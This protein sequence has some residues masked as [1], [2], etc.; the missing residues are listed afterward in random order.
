M[1]SF[2]SSVYLARF[3]IAVNSTAYL[4]DT[5]AI[6]KKMKGNSWIQFPMQINHLFLVPSGTLSKNFVK[7]T[8]YI[9]RVI[10]PTDK[11]STKTVIT[12][13]HVTDYVTPLVNPLKGRDVT[14]LY[15]AMQ[16]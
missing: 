6:L 8:F 16:V 10:L 3:L 5:F 4:Q 14:W 1:T 9:F 12:L 7:Y 2:S 13:H 11:F 15:F